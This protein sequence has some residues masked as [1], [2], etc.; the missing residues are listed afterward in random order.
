MLKDMHI[1]KKL[2][3]L[4]AYEKTLIQSFKTN[5]RAKCGLLDTTV[6]L[7]K[8]PMSTIFLKCISVLIPK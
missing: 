5:C 8:L 2:A 7:L 4:V 1:E 3:E 6:F